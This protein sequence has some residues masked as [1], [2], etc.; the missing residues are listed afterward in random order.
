[1]KNMRQLIDDMS[2]ES[3]LVQDSNP[4]MRES[5]SLLEK[6]MKNV[7]LAA[8]ELI[9]NGEQIHNTQHSTQIK[10]SKGGGYQS[11][12]WHGFTPAPDRKTTVHTKG[13]GSVETKTEP[14]S[15][16]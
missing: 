8:T 11:T 5:D 12:F 7:A 2:A 13:D 10:D 16:L 9:K 3:V 1:M 6:H 4:K 15:Q 14:V